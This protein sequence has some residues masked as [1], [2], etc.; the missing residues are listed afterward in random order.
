MGVLKPRN[1]IMRVPTSGIGTRSLAHLSLFFFR[2]WIGG[3]GREVRDE[4]CKDGKGGQRCGD[5][6]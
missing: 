3:E 4:T 5:N 6:R 1:N 2:Q